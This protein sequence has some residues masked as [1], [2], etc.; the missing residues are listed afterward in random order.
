MSAPINRLVDGILDIQNWLET[1][2]LPCGSDVTI[3]I[4]LPTRISV[5]DAKLIATHDWPSDLPD[6]PKLSG[7]FK[8]AGVTVL[9][10]E[11]TPKVAK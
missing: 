9:F 8:L 11:N 7:D 6:P 2:N 4:R 10:E 3:A 1:H 5:V